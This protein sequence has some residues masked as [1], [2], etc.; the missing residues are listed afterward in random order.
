VLLV[1][2]P[3]LRVRF[4]RLFRTIEISFILNEKSARITNN[5]ASKGRRISREIGAHISVL[6][7]YLLA[8]L[9]L[10]SLVLY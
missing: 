6:A 9:L 4:V 2:F 1:Q 5:G 10:G 8:H 7:I 3:Y